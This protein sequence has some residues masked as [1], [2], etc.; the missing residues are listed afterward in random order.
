MEKVSRKYYEK[1]ILNIALLIGSIGVLLLAV[2]SGFE[3]HSNK[4]VSGLFEQIGSMSSSHELDNDVIPESL[5]KQAQALVDNKYS[6]IQSIGMKF[7][8]IGQ[9]NLEGH[10]LYSYPSIIEV[11]EFGILKY[12]SYDQ[13]S[14]TYTGGQGLTARIRD[15]NRQI[16][17]DIAQLKFTQT[18]DITTKSLLAGYWLLFT[19]WG[20]MNIVRNNDFHVKWVVLL[21]LFNVF[22]Y[23]LYTERRTRIKTVVVSSGL[24]LLGAWIAYNGIQILLT[25][26]RG[27]VFMY[28]LGIPIE[29]TD[30]HVYLYG[31]LF[32]AVGVV[33]FFAPT[34]LK[35]I[36]KNILSSN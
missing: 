4:L 12:G 26:T 30:F 36:L 14:I 20:V 22:G 24:Y 34:T 7:N 15:T 16:N 13:K 19:I 6:G 21:S 11:N 8:T 28:K 31:S 29:L 9:S 32:L 5:K 3:S 25:R 2:S 1:Y 17:V 23:W 27:T 33:L 10:Y 18:Y 35:P